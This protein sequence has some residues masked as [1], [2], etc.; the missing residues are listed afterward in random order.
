MLGSRQ[1]VNAFSGSVACRINLKYVYFSVTEN[2]SVLCLDYNS[3]YSWKFCTK[4][5]VCLIFAVK[6]LTSTVNF[7]IQLHKFVIIYY[8]RSLAI[9]YFHLYKFAKMSHKAGTQKH[10]NNEKGKKDGFTR[11]NVTV[12][13]KLLWQYRI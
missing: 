7:Y 9:T 13:R 12:L 2:N 6:N 4:K 3:S 5:K 8:C 10:N 1:T 11:G